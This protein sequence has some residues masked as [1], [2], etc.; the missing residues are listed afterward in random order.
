MQ[1]ITVYGIETLLPYGLPDRS[2][3]C[4]QPITVYGIETSGHDICEL[5]P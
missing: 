2:W 3:K 5:P 1:P 4:M